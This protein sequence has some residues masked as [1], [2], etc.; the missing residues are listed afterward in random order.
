MAF[1]VVVVGYLT[2]VAAAKVAAAGVASVASAGVAVVPPATVTPV[3]ALGVA[4]TEKEYCAIEPGAAALEFA[5]ESVMTPPDDTVAGV[6][7]NTAVGAAWMVT[8]AVTGALCTPKLS[9][10]IN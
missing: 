1:L 10:T 9:V 3:G 6:A 4:S 5:A 7:A 2:G 8:V